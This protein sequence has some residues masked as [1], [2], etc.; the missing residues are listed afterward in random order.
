M[1]PEA[2]T[3]MADTL[4]QT[5]TVFTADGQYLFRFGGLGARPG[6]LGYPSDV[7]MD[8][9]GRLYVTETANAR[10]QVFE[11]VE[12]PAAAPAAGRADPASQ[13]VRDRVRQELSGVLRALRN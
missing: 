8:Q 1:V 9:A 6:D 13:Q 4:R 11:P 5:V 12:G 10:L 2:S 7:G 3:A